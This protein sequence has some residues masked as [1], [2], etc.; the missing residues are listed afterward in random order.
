MYS[1]VLSPKDMQVAIK[2]IRNFFEEEMVS[3]LN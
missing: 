2:L 3:V 1:Q